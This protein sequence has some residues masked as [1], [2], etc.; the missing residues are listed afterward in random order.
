MTTKASSPV[1]IV[2]LALSEVDAARYLGVPRRTLQQLRWLGGG[3][4]FVKLGRSVLYRATDLKVWIEQKG[5]LKR[6][7]SD[8]GEPLQDS[9]DAHA[10]PLSAVVGTEGPATLRRKEP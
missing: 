6:S 9:D 7:T 1:H 8:D 5:V 4:V 10:K 3:P 2:P